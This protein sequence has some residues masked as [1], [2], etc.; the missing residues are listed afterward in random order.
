MKRLYMSFFNMLWWSM[1]MSPMHRG[2]M[3]DLFVCD[4]DW[5]LPRQCRQLLNSLT[6]QS[7]Q[8][9]KARLTAISAGTTHRWGEAM[10]QTGQDH[11]LTVHPFIQRFS[12]EFVSVA[13]SGNESGAKNESN[14]KVSLQ[15]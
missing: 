8:G 12:A 2:P 4:T 15:L 13:T 5:H 3:Q 14:S 10:E 9:F 11:A 6:T 7:C 1:A